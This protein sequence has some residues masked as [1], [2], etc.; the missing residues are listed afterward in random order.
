MKPSSAKPTVLDFK[1]LKKLILIYY[2]N[3]KNNF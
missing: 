3:I 2:Y 1:S